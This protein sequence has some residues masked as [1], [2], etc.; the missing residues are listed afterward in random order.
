M[1]S[2]RWLIVAV[3]AA[4]ILAALAL[5]LG[6]L[7][8]SDDERTAEAGSDQSPTGQGST[9]PDASGGLPAPG[10]STSPLPD[11]GDSA[12]SGGGAGSAQERE[13]GASPTGGGGTGSP[14]SPP[15]Q[16][17]PSPPAQP[18]PIPC[19]VAVYSGPMPGIPN[20]RIV[21]TADPNVDMVWATVSEGAR[22]LRG[23]IAL[24][25]GRGEQIVDG[26]SQRARVIVFSDASMAEPTK[27]CS[28]VAD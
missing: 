21:V 6:T 22:S 24:A 14:P 17:P 10:P 8:S 27:S 23:A 18:T 3:V 7:R 19:S 28:N 13:P 16:P 15:P 9:S 20:I 4:V 11:S 25:G 2:R 5:M 1:G 26:V 12:A